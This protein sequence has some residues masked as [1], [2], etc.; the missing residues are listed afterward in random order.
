MRLNEGMSRALDTL[1]ARMKFARERAKLTQ[2]QLAELSVMRQPDISKIE[3]GSIQKTTG[4]ARLAMA[5][6]VEP[7]WL[8]LGNGEMAPAASTSNLRTSEAAKAH[9]SP[10]FSRDQQ[11]PLDH[12][13]SHRQ[14]IVTPKT[15]VWEDLVKETIEGQ[16]LL[17]VK[18]EALMPT[19][20]PGQMAIWQACD[21]KDASPGQAVLI[22][23]PGDHFEL[24]FLERRGASWAGV[25]QRIGH[26][27]L[28]PERDQAVV[29][30]RLR[31]PDLG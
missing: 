29:V 15:M 30:A 19:W 10:A 1:A 31:Y 14:P 12:D 13:V 2:K 18:G 26:G 23:L 21:H 24:R 20:P 27:E 16:F 17:A 3:L 4:I 22:R 11:S 7:E 8:E 28:L 9:G 6:K 5:L 25:S